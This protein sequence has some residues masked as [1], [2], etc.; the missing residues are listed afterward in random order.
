MLNAVEPG[1]VIPI[2]RHQKTS[3]TMEVLLGRVVVELYDELERICLQLVRYILC[4]SSMQE[5]VILVQKS[6]CVIPVDINM[7]LYI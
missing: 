2:H 1:S 6:L 7:L 5:P 4:G 3:E